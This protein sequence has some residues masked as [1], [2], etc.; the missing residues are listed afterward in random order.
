MIFFF[1]DCVPILLFPKW[2]VL[3]PFTTVPTGVFA[4]TTKWGK[5]GKKVKET[6]KEKDDKDA[7]LDEHNYCPPGCLS[8]G[9][10]YMPPGKKVKFIVTK[11][12]IPFDFPVKMAV[13]LD[14][15]FV[16]VD[17]LIMFNI[18]NPLRFISTLSPY[19]LT[20]LLESFLEESVRSLAR[21]CTYTEVYNLRGYNLES[22]VRE[23]ND[24]LQEY[25]VYVRQINVTQIELPED[26]QDSMKTY[27]FYE[28]KE[29]LRAKEILFKQLKIDNEEDYKDTKRKRENGLLKRQATDYMKLQLVRKDVDELKGITQKRMAQIRSE[30]EHD[31]AYKGNM[32]DVEVAK[33]NTEQENYMKLIRQQ[34]RKDRDVLKVKEQE[35]RGVKES[36]VQLKLSENRAL[37]VSE[38]A[39]AEGKA[40]KKLIAKRN[41][42]LALGNVEILDGLCSNEG[43]YVS[44]SSNYSPLAQLSG[45]VDPEQL[46]MGKELA[47]YI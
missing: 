19:Q 47:E 14:N 30:K 16:S 1:S 10:H 20:E 38:T 3:D 36:I 40:S 21:Q 29:I 44:G 4:I 32:A 27:T 9:I 8:P 26:L 17:T 24:K 5:I 28:S 7:H 25:G 2:R 23:L 35:Y 39:K 18:V 37:I 13:T 22:M 11:S 42:E 12:F 46:V 43:C 41:Y 6:L 31:V 15:V 33:M 45:I 34:G